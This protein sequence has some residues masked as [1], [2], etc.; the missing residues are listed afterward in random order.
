ML[1]KI[2]YDQ[3]PEQRKWN[4][5][6]DVYNSVDLQPSNLFMFFF[7]YYYYLQWVSMFAFALSL[8]DEKI[9]P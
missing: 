3:V 1:K 7:N 2:A 4:L 8:Q 9:V 6:K 5:E